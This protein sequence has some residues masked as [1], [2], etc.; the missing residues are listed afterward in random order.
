[1]VADEQNT[2]PD[3]NPPKESPKI[4]GSISDANNTP[5]EST[6]SQESNNEENKQQNIKKYIYSYVDKRED[7]EAKIAN[8]LTK[9]GIVI[10]FFLFCITLFALMQ[11]KKSV[12]ISDAGL[13][14]M[15]R[16]AAINEGRNIVRDSTDSISLKISES[17]LNAQVSTIKEAQKQFEI[18]NRPYI[19]FVEIKVDTLIGKYGKEN[20]FVKLKMNNYGKNPGFIKKI[21][22][23]ATILDGN[24]L[25]DIPPYKRSISIDMIVLPD[26]EMFI[27]VSGSNIENGMYSQIF[28]GRITFFIYAEII[29]SDI[30]NLHIY[31]TSGCYKAIFNNKNELVIDRNFIH[32]YTKMSVIK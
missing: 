28:K 8:N 4:D 31:K 23:G 7:K 17:S 32:P 12:D 3:N 21:S 20:V 26:I 14:E 16:Q 6:D 11:T 1:M 27:N 10:N 18:E 30:F 25:V 15:K 9:W 13:K 2:N 5:R 19:S 29:Y 24:E 22:T